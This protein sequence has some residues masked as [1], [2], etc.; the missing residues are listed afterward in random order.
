M[1]FFK[2]TERSREYFE[3]KDGLEL[4]GYSD[5]IHIECGDARHV[6]L[7]GKE[8][9]EIVSYWAKELGIIPK[10]RKAISRRGKKP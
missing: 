6:S 10:K 7:K 2:G 3:S 5:S 4:W 8:A 1:K 9:K